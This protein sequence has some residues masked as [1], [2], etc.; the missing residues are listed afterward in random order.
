M[1]TIGQLKQVKHPE[2]F[3]NVLKH[4]LVIQVADQNGILSTSYVSLNGKINMYRT[5]IAF[6]ISHFIY[7]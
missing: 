5:K 4:Y 2:Y 3:I 6:I 7:T 1:T